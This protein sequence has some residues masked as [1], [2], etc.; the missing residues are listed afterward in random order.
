MP[1]WRESLQSGEWYWHYKAKNGA[2]TGFVTR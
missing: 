1:D 2:A